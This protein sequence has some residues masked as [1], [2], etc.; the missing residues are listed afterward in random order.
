M[1]PAIDP[2]PL[3][4]GRLAA[5]LLAASVW[6]DKAL[7]SRLEQRGWPALSATRSR[8]FL[9]LSRG[10]VL[11]SELARE[12]DV[13]RQ[14]VH[15]LLDG[16]QGDGLVDRHADA[17]DRRAQVVTLTERGHALAADAGRIL[18]ELEDELARRIGSDR[19]EALREALAH[20]RGPS[21]EAS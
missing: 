14:A 1:S 6:F 4:P 8:V 15:K 7:L 21:P 11:V 17:R 5:E 19:V 16:L 20:D 2:P 13:S 18:P 3:Q 12:L 9:A 10:P